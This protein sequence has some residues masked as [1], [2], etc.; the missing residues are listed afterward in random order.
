MKKFFI[1]LMFAMFGISA[2][3]QWIQ[4]S[5]DS[6]SVTSLT[7]KGDTIFAG[8]WGDGIYLSDNN[9]SSWSETG[10]NHNI[11]VKSLIT[12]DSNVFPRELMVVSFCIQIQE[13]IGIR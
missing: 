3:A 13:T 7:I 2:N 8:T 6:G 1:V 4:T 11:P 12:S 9:G 10:Y 5:L